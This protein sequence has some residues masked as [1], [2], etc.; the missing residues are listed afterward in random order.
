MFIAMNRFRV[1]KGSEE[2]FEKVWLSRDTQLAKVPGFVE[3]GAPR[4]CTYRRRCPRLFAEGAFM[5]NIQE[6]LNVEQ[7]W[8]PSTLTTSSTLG[9]ATLSPAVVISPRQRKNAHLLDGPVY[10]SMPW[11]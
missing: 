10:E 7:M 11:G 2:A 1:K 6:G 3:S 9:Q 5:F 8:A 4:G